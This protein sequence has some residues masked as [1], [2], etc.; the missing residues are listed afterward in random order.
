MPN[1]PQYSP[2]DYVVIKYSKK[3]GRQ[4]LQQPDTSNHLNTTDTKWV[5]SAIGGL[6]Y[7]ARA[8][9]S[10]NLPALNH[11][12]TEQAEPIVYTKMKN[13]LFVRLR[14]Y[15]SKRTITFLRIRYVIKY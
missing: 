5:Q 9:Y 13:T 14:G 10:T 8:M 3:G 2:H 6:L 1:A 15:I 7:Y 4:Y 11:L 12:G